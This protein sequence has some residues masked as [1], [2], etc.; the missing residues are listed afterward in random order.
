MSGINLRLSER[1]G[2][3]GEAM[4]SGMLQEITAEGRSRRVSV[5][6]EKVFLMLHHVNYCYS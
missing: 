2:Q 5:N 1:P 3:E 4:E 6:L